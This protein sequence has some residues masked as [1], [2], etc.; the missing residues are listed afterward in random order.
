MNVGDSIRRLLLGAAITIVAFSAVANAAAVGTAADDTA[1]EPK[2]FAERAGEI[3][4]RIEELKTA[5]DAIAFSRIGS[6]LFQLAPMPKD[7][8]RVQHKAEMMQKL[9]LR[10]RA[11]RVANDRVGPA[12]DPAK[13]VPP[14]VLS[15]EG[16]YP[17]GI[18]PD[19]TTDPVLRQK[20][21]ENDRNFK[22]FQMQLTAGRI[23]EDLAF[24]IAVTVRR[25]FTK[26]DQAEL[27]NLVKEESPDAV[28]EAQIQRALARTDAVRKLDPD[29]QVK[30]RREPKGDEI[31][32]EEPVLREPGPAS[33]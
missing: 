31:K 20:I 14:R 4:V 9:R 30:F 29:A 13:N 7:R 10:L 32:P 1:A 6:D 17:N 33:P 12:F 26:A 3:A 23:A 27:D 11:M 19:S 15:L 18:S 21:E 16:G 22:R 2:P 28:S 24:A 8:D 5:Q 25:N